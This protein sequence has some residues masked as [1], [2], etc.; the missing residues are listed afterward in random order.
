M[1][2]LVFHD[3]LLR[4]EAILWRVLG[5]AVAKES[6]LYDFIRARDAVLIVG[7]LEAVKLGG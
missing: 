5:L 3:H 1:L 7:F 4:I 6:P 2:Y